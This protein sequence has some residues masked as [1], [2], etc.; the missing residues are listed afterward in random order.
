MVQLMSGS[1]S[2]LVTPD[3]TPRPTIEPP[4]ITTIDQV[5]DRLRDPRVAARLRIQ[6]VALKAIHDIMEREK[7]TQLLP[8]MLSPITDPLNHSVHDAAIRYDGRELQLTKSMILHKQVALLADIDRLYIMSPN[9]RLETKQC[10]TSGRHLLEFTQVDIEFRGATRDEFLAFMERVVVHV[11]A[12]VVSRCAG[13]LHLLGR[14]LRVPTAPFTRYESKDLEGR[15]GPAWEKVGSAQAAEPFWVFDLKREFYDREDPKR[16]GYFVN[17][18]L[19]WPEGFGEALSGAERDWEHDVLLRKI[20]ERGQD[21]ASF[22]PYLALAERGLLGP[23]AGGGLGVERL[24][25][26]LTGAKHIGD[27]ALFPRIP[28]TPVIL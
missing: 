27:A 28:G 18:D 25:R 3:T 5:A 10:R 8:V 23:S 2:R 16:P 21:A 9:V 17:Y 24:V 1:T 12:R 15:L 20:K 11:I 13:D 14:T 22:A 6:N 19:I 26:F 4:S 7:V